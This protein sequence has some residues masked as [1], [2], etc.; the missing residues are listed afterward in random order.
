MPI[1]TTNAIS[2][3]YY[4]NGVATSFPFTFEVLSADQVVVYVNGG[5]VSDSSYSVALAGDSPSKGTVTF[6]TAPAS[7]GEIYTVLDPAFSQD[8]EFADGAPYLAKAHN[9][10]Y[11]Q[12]ALRDQALARDLS[13]SIKAPMWE[14]IGSLPPK[15][16][17]QN[18]IQ[19]F[20]V[21]GDPTAV[22][23]PNIQ[24]LANLRSYGIDILDTGAADAVQADV[25]PYLIEA[26]ADAKRWGIGRVNFPGDGFDFCVKPN[27]TTYGTFTM[28]AG[29]IIPF[30]RGIIPLV[31][32]VA[33]VGQ[34]ARLYH[35]GGQVDPGG[36]FYTPFWEDD[37]QI[38]NVA[39]VGLTLDGNLEN[40]TVTQYA[41]ATTGDGVWQHGHA[42][43]GASLRRFM[44][45]RCPVKGF[46]GFG[47]FGTSL[48]GYVT[49]HF[50]LIDN[51]ISNCFQGGFQ[52]ALN[53]FH[54]ERN[55]YH[56][57][58]GWV[59]LGF[60]I[61]PAA[62][63]ESSRYIRSIN[64][65]IDGRDGLSS[66][67]ATAIDWAGYTGVATDS[68]EADD[69]RVMRRRGHVASGDYYEDSPNLGQR[70]DIQISGL[71]SYEAG[72]TIT[73]FSD[74][75]I[76]NT[77]I[78]LSYVPDVSRYNPPVGNAI[79]VTPGGLDE[80]NEGL[81]I[82]GVQ[83]RTDDSLPSIL[84]TKMKMC[85]VSATVIGGRSAPLRLN[86]CGGQFNIVT[87]DF[88]MAATGSI[89]GNYGSTSSGV[90]AYG[91]AG[92]IDIT[93]QVQETRSSG[94]RQV[95]YAAYL[96]VDTTYP[97]I[98][99]GSS[100]GHLVAPIRDVNGTAIN[101]GLIDASV[102]KLDVNVPVVLRNGLES[103]GAADFFAD[104]GDLNF[105]LHSV[106]GT[107]RNINTIS[108]SGLQTQFSHTADG[109]MQLNQFNDGV[110]QRTPMRWD[111]NGV[112]F[113]QA[114]YDMPLQYANAWLW[115]SASQV[116]RISGVKPTADSDG[117]AVGSQT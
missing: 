86:A 67:V 103:H 4:G 45:K 111:E 6:T 41:R 24:N 44:L 49:D 43:T 112:L 35:E 23:F 114:T 85:N 26:M 92:P 8:I 40:Q 31:S 27:Y 117:V 104:T 17:R 115:A 34:G 69:L 68:P 99:R 50:S 13:R 47:V 57:D 88:G 42:I 81:T 33:L 107:R 91:N 37:G 52:G 78:Q 90:T 89:D 39:I 105:N 80:Y 58:G 71:Q 82:N 110:P 1:G 2:G 20:D 19:G 62:A 79:A 54:S 102:R 5:L 56:G 16:Q 14:T 66:P 9:D 95:Q 11:D 109:G 93:V 84:L 55:Y 63:S 75:Q 12:S 60:N 46:L 28:Q 116:L 32:N 48:G 94:A 22:T 61:E 10:G 70:A 21:N 74:V 38:E 36:F 108:A 51:D 59:A 3:P 64:D 7:G 15:A 77:I 98:V 96:N 100:T 97:V 73:G 53:F 83:I 18:S 29:N 30:K 76:T 25:A 106:D 87:R 101:A 72:V 113:M 65:T